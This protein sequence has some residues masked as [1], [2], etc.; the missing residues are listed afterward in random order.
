M[1]S[2]LRASSHNGPYKNNHLAQHT[3]VRRNKYL[4]KTGCSF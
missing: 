3:K 4:E 1:K 2:Y